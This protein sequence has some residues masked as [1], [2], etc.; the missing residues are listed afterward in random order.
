VRALRAIGLTAAAFAGGF[1]AAALAVKS[2]LPSQGDA[3]SDEL[4]LVAIFDGI[5][6]ESRSA[7]FRGGS[8]LAW[9]GGIDADLR[10]AQLAPGAELTLTSLFGGISLRIPVGW[11]VES[12]G[13]AIAGGIADAVP[14]PE[15][16][17]APRLVLT[18]VAVLGG[19]AVRADA[20]DNASDA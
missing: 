2:A 7:S 10:H 20:P 11:R 13:R 6:L 18:S 8:M 5:E 12:T 3:D 14:E 4:G 1:V 9:F 19:V 15:D 17:D 16:P